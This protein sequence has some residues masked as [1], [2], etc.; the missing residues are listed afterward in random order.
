MNYTLT[1]KEEVNDNNIISTLQKLLILLN[2]EKGDL[3]KSLIFI[4]I[5]YSLTLTAPIIIGHVVDTYIQ[6]KDYNSLFNYSI[7]LLI[8]YIVCLITN[9]FQTKMMGVLGQKTIF[10]LRNKIFLKLQELPIDFFNKNRIG[11]LISRINNDTSKL[12]QFFAQSLS[13]FVGNIFIMFGAAIFLLSINFYLGFL[14]IIPAFLLLIFNKIFSVYLKEQNKES[15]KSMGNLNSEIQESL[16]NFKVIDS[17][18]IGSYFR[19]KFNLQN[20]D[21]YKKAL[22]TGISNSIFVP[23]Y[24]LSSNIAQIIVLYFGINLIIQG[25][26]SVGLL[27]SFLTYTVRFY[28]PIRQV[29]FLWTSFQTALAGWDR[30]YEVLQLKTNL[31]II[32]SEP[33]NS[34][35]NSVLEFKNVSFGY[36]PEKLILKN[37]SFSLEK[38]K[39]YAL[40]GPTGGGKTTTANLMARLYD[41]LEGKVILDNKDIRSYKPNEKTKKIGFILQ[42]P[43][44]FTGT[45]KDNILYGNDE[46]KYYSTEELHHLIKELD[47]NDLITKFDNGLETNISSNSDGI[48]LGEKQIIAFIRAL[49]RKPEIIILDEATA[50]LDTVTEKILD[51]ILDKLPKSTVKVII[52]HRLNTIRSAD[53]IFFINAGNI[54]FANS[55]EEAI[56]I[57]LHQ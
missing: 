1:K 56:K 37:I 14:A 32:K 22:K 51:D 25:K 29:A 18:N 42:E 28:D 45:I 4:I 24:N 2:E 8:I 10:N 57:F 33:L 5:N 30:I 21:N 23:A 36:S 55:M 41:P 27:I 40:V 26:F 46:Y 50:N 47:L 31:D 54:T 7:L 6:K 13:Q 43:F 20:E 9:Y 39:T 12:S 15:L 53:K 52:A 34:D 19:E 44:L 16:N 17:L 11:D 3:V 48:S 49:I 38:G 35:I